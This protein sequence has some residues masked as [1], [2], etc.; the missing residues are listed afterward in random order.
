MPYVMQVFE[1]MEALKI[2]GKTSRDCANDVSAFGFSNMA[3][4]VLKWSL[5]GDLGV[6]GILVHV[7]RRISS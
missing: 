4:G 6:G 2:A 3:R 1:A 7:A 5:G